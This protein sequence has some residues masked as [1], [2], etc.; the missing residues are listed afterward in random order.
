MAPD[1]NVAEDGHAR[2]QW[3]GRPLVPGRF[4]AQRKFD[5]GMVGR[6]SVGGEGRADVGWGK[7]VEGVTKKWDMI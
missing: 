7:L 1:T 2:Q 4:D 5:A 6:E 3:D